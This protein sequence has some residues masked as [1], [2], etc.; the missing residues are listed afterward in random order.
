LS[1]A[2]QSTPAKPT[3]RPASRQPPGRSFSQAQ[4]MSTPHSG[5]VAL[6][7]ADSPPVMASAA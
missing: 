3:A 5:V 2:S 6:K 4:A 7:M 1:P